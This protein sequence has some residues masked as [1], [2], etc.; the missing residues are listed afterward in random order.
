MLA[1]LAPILGNDLF[2]IQETML[3]TF[4]GF[5]ANHPLSQ[6]ARKRLLAVNEA[7]AVK[8][9][10]EIAGIEKMKDGMLNASNILVHRHPVCHRFLIK[11]PFVMTGAAIA[12]KIP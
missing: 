12:F 6:E 2:R 9:P 7:K 11:H 10:G 5:F 4:H 3:R 1:G 8:N